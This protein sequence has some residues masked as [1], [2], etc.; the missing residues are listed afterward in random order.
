MNETLSYYDDNAE[1]FEADTLSA[2]M[3]EAQGCFIALLASKSHILDFGCG[4]GRDGLF[5]LENGFLVDA[6]DGSKAMCNVAERNIQQPVRRMK[7]DQLDAVDKY[8]GV[9]ACASLLHIPKK[10]FPGILRLVHRAL[11]KD[12]IF[13]LSVKEGTFEGIRNGRY[14]SDYRSEEIKEL[15][16]GTG[17][18][19]LDLWMSKD[20]R[21]GRDDNWINII[22]KKVISY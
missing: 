11:K 22:N 14:F 19:V 15:L 5:F 9:W 21:P 1:S 7:F 20:V 6:V 18:R 8:D 12:G 4:A 16:T 10:D 3:S 2:D 17:Y 13:Y